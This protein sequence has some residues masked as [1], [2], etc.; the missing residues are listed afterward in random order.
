MIIASG[1]F[2]VPMVFAGLV[3]LAAMGV[4]L[5]LASSWLEQRLTGWANRKS[6]FAMV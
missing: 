3:I 1:N 5:Y 2:D 4:V 6:E